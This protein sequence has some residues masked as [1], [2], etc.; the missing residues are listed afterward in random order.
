M[1][2]YESGKVSEHFSSVELIDPSDIAQ[3]DSSPFPSFGRLPCWCNGTNLYKVSMLRKTRASTNNNRAFE[4]VRAKHI[5]LVD[6]YFPG[7]LSF[8]VMFIGSRI[9]D[10][11]AI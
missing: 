10:S 6:D 4:R 9:P 3:E 8:H 11:P 7:V 1:C 5:H 2:L